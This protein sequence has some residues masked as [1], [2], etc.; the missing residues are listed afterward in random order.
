MRS[1]LVFV[2]LVAASAGAWAQ[3]RPAPPKDSAAEARLGSCPAHKFETHVRAIVDGKPRSSR[4]KLCGKVGQTDAEWAR[5]LADGLNKLEDDQAMPAAT[6][7]QIAAALKA[8]IAKFSAA[9]PVAAGPAPAIAAPAPAP[10]PEYSA[11]PPLPAPPRGPPAAAPLAEYSPLPALPTAPAVS[12][13]RPIL[14]GEQPRVTLLC[15]VP[16]DIGGAQPCEELQRDTLLIVRADAALAKAA[17]L[18]FLRKGDPRGEIALS[19]MGKGRSARFA[20]PRDLCAG[21][22]SSRVEIE[23]VNAAGQVARTDGPYRLSC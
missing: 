13:A 14:V 4:V 23:L 9:A 22:A 17:T 11:L 12:P 8:E 6:K 10:F 20:L 15:L 7:D 5:T 18:R 2:I 16:G 19:P 21:I 3:A 1:A